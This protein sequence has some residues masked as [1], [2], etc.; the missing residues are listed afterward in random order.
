M[1]LF[2]SGSVSFGQQTLWRTVNVMGDHFEAIAAFYYWEKS[3]QRN[4][5]I[6]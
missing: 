1:S 3:L 4:L 5:I 6:N 2:G